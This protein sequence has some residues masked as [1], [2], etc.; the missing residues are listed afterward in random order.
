[1]ADQK[2]KKTSGDL[3]KGATG[4]D[5]THVQ[6]YLERF[7]YLGASRRS[8]ETFGAAPFPMA[9]GDDLASPRRAASRCEKG[10]FDDS[11]AE[12][13]RRF[14]EFAGLPVTGVVDEATAA[15]MNQPRCGNPDTPGSPS[16]STSGRKWATNNLRYA[17]QNFT[18]DLTSGRITVAIEQAFALW[19][20]YTPLRFTPVRWRPGRRS[21]S[22]S[23]PAT[24]GTVR[25]STDRA[26]CWRTPSSPRSRPRP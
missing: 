23:S 12:A 10:A 19:A 3:T 25:P 15:K 5:V 17:F 24:T 14:Q 11:T 22:G 1:M 21:S 20:A 16:S 7:G 13:V 2:K 6:E 9:E 18:P 26:A 8:C 4:A